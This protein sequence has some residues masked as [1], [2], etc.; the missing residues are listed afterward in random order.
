MRGGPALVRPDCWF[1]RTAGLSRLSALS[2]SDM[3][4]L[5]LGFPITNGMVV[6]QGRDF[7]VWGRDRAG[8]RMTLTLEGAPERRTHEVVADEQGR[9]RVS[10]LPLPAGGPYRMVVE[11][12][13]TA[14]VEDILCGEVWLAS[15]QSN[16]EWPVSA[17]DDADAEIEA[18]DDPLLRVLK[19][20]K[21]TAWDPSDSAVGSWERTSPDTA[22]RFTAVGYYFAGQ[23]R[24]KLG[25]PVGII[26][27]TWG[28]TII[29][30]WTSVPGQRAVHPRVDEDLRSVLERMHELPEL[31]AEHAAK[32]TDWENRSLPADP[33]LETRYAQ[34][35]FDD[36][37]WDTMSLPAFW[38]HRGMAFNGVV[39]FRRSVEV[40]AEWA[41]RAL[42]LSLGAIDDF[43]HTFFNGELVGAHP[44]GTPEACKLSRRYIIPAE[45]VR[46]GK[47]VIA[48]RVFDHVGEGGFAGP[49]REMALAPTDESAAELPLA[50][51]WQL[52][53]EHPL[54]PVPG[55]VWATHPTP[56]LMLTP[57]HMPAALHNG[58]IAPVAPYGVRGVLWYQGESDVERHAEYADRQRALVR[59]LRAHFGQDS[60][61][62]FF[63]ELAGYRGGPTWPLLR[64]A[65]QRAASEPHTALITA[66]DIGDPGDIHPRNKQEVGRRLSLLARSLVYGD[67]IEASGPTF[68]R[69]EMDGQRARVWFSSKSK[70]R[71][72]DPGRVSGFEL[73]GRD[74]AF[75]CAEAAI[76]DDHVVVQSARVPE[77]THV[78]YAF[79]DTGEGDLENAAG[80]PALSFRTD[81]PYGAMTESRD[82]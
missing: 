72:R 80:L 17:S 79:T 9:F 70:L 65:Q 45:L 49:R 68:A 30:A 7:L 13:G 62:F 33:P 52:F 22:P 10:C 39:W 6:Q 29:S 41:G 73:A 81:G 11:G 42:V 63:V 15:G 48:V 75:H 21:Q 61:P 18:A 32:L 2:E 1:G 38:Q 12:S 20:Q 58:M 5:R 53:A 24:Q 60:L 4:E 74:G 14:V 23:L 47:N 59:D 36:S 78:R 3:S 56:P 82:V 19:V 46:P 8:Q 67:T 69:V 34:A 16:M 44:K 77:P 76:T 40:P 64:E 35:S 25:V 26:D 66:R 31:R 51:P 37:D 55:S 50:G 54:P 28:G 57:E 43:D 71:S 27:A